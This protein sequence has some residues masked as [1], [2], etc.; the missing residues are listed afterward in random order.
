MY[1][2]YYNN[3]QTQVRVQSSEGVSMKTSEEYCINSAASN[4]NCA[5]GD[6]VV[7]TYEYNHPNLLMTGMLVTAPDGSRRTCF[8]YDDYGNQIEVTTPNA[9]LSSCP[10]VAP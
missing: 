10:G 9:N 7:T 3:A 1:A 6:E 4:G 5:L 2:T 8:K